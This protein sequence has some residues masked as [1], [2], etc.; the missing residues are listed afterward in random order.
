[1][2]LPVKRLNVMGDRYRVLVRKMDEFGMCF[3]IK[4]E[5]H[6]R[7]NQSEDQA[8]DTLLHEVIHAID[9]VETLNLTEEQ[10]RTLATD[11]RAVFTA[12]PDFAKW[13]CR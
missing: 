7:P 2:Q 5:I 6:V 3:F 11:L 9:N 1:V 13:V 4:G 8:R 10:V 12:N